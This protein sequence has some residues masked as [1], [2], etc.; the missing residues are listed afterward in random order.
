M[1]EYLLLFQR[2]KKPTLLVNFNY[3]LFN[4]NKIILKCLQK[5]EK[6]FS[7]RHSA[8]LH[9]VREFDILA[10]DIELP[11]SLSED[12]GQHSTSVYAH[13]HVDR[14]IGLLLHVLDGVH[15]R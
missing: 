11:L 13:P 6:R 7:P 15:H 3:T 8:A 5:E 2:I 9:L 14:T 10:V 12:T 1:F 4:S